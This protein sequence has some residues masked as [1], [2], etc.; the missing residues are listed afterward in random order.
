MPIFKSIG[1]RG[2]EITILSKIGQI[3][4]DL[5]DKKKALDY[6]NQARSLNDSINDPTFNKNVENRA[7]IPLS[8]TNKTNKVK[9]RQ[10]PTFEAVRINEYSPPE[11][12]IKNDT[13]RILTFKIGT[14]TYKISA[15][16]S[17]NISISP[18]SFQV[19]V[20]VPSIAPLVGYKTFQTGYRYSITY[21]IK[22]TY[23]K[24]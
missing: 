2:L 17:K 20:M 8:P 7:D 19:H 11:I 13:E 5:G 12:E 3:Y 22:T 14:S 1:F 6:N 24:R 10:T 15:N 18:G 9:Q 23:V 21:R 4:F 16:T